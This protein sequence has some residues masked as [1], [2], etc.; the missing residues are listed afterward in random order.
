MSIASTMNSFIQSMSGTNPP[1]V[2]NAGGSATQVTDLT[3]TTRN[4][5]GSSNQQQGENDWLQR[6]LFNKLSPW[7]KRK[8]TLDRV[9]RKVPKNQY[10]EQAH[11]LRWNPIQTLVCWGKNFIIISYTQRSDEVFAFSLPSTVELIV[12]GATAYT[13]LTSG[14]H[15]DKLAYWSSTKHSIMARDWTIRC[16]TRI[17]LES[18]R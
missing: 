7:F 4:I 15:Q 13:C 10:H 2:I 18:S 6:P 11:I 12:P 1:P 16:L 8:G 14:Q 3:G 17:R 5:I 9:N